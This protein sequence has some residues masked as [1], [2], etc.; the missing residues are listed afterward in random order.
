MAKSSI[1][2][3]NK[4][5]NEEKRVHKIP[6]KK[7]GVSK[8]G[9]SKEQT[10]STIKSIKKELEKK[11]KNEDYSV[12][13]EPRKNYSSSSLGGLEKKSKI[14]SEAPSKLRS[15][16]LHLKK[17]KEKKNSSES[18]SENLSES[19]S[20][21]SSKESLVKVPS[22]R[23]SSEDSDSEDSSESSSSENLSENLK[24]SG[25]I[26]KKTDISGSSNDSSSSDSSNSSNESCLSDESSSDDSSSDLDSNSDSNSSSDDS[27]SEN[28]LKS[29]TSIDSTV[30][31]MQETKEKVNSGV[32]P[33]KRKTETKVE[34]LT[35]KSGQNPI[36][37]K[38]ERINIQKYNENQDDELSDVEKLN[39]NES[40]NNRLIDNKKMKDDEDS[41]DSDSDSHSTS[42]NNDDSDDNKNS[43]STDGFHTIN[44][45]NNNSAGDSDDSTSSSTSSSSGDSSDLT[46]NSSGDSANNVVTD[47]TSD[48]ETQSD[49]N[50]NAK[51]STK[52]TFSKKKN[53]ETKIPLENVSKNKNI[54]DNFSK[55]KNISK[56]NKHVSKTENFDNIDDKLEKEISDFSPHDSAKKLSD[57]KNI[58]HKDNKNTS[59]KRK[60]APIEIDKKETK[61]NKTNTGQDAEGSKTIFVG[62]LSWNVDD[63]WLAK[64][65]ESVGTV[66]SSRVITNKNS[67]KSKGFGYVEFSTP[68]E[69]QAALTYSGKEIDGRVINVDI[70]T[71]L[72]ANL[73]NNASTRANKY[74]DIRSPKSD[75]LFIG[76]LSF[77]ANEE[78][79]RTAFSRIGGIVEIRLPTN[80]KTGQLKGFGY[81]QFSSIEDAE[82]AIEMN[83]H[84]ISGRPI[85]LD[86]S[87]KKNNNTAHATFNNSLNN[88]KKKDH[89]APQRA[90]FGGKTNS[91]NRSGFNEFSGKKT[92]F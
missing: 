69:A 36:E 87:T 65:F 8:P 86:F 84:F 54:N 2:K 49:T 48:S 83:G 76:N 37:N 4:N 60:D 82:K 22:S 89:K 45:S 59:K 50:K 56:K 90:N 68:E 23:N 32:G 92:K 6:A 78:A 46:S 42:N 44:D 52:N 41:S 88:Y 12:M 71:G 66:L 62:G 77:K 73:K 14:A 40:Y 27:N 61:K 55:S 51:H 70:S 20:K 33:K 31:K 5:T 35:K 28:S 64:E 24:L 11:K 10:K 1:K 7:G 25:N 3:E 43:T 39:S 38:T 18:S 26:L 21:S 75:T 34:N 63:N 13:K 53:K 16:E 85:R 17:F 72:S 9:V 29:S 47:S 57:N 15:E 58:K 67:G 74:G 19:S 80:R 81:I 91:T 30:K 79:V